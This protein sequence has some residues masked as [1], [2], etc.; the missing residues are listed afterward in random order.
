[1][2]YA[3]ILGVLAVV[4]LIFIMLK[5]RNKEEASVKNN[6]SSTRRVSNDNDGEEL[7]DSDV[8]I[9]QINASVSDEGQ[10]WEWDTNNADLSTTSVSAQEVDPLTEYQVY[11]QF[12]YEDKAA[13]SLAKYLNA[14]K[15]DV[16][17]RLVNELVGLCLNIRDVDLLS[18]SLS[19]YASVLSQTALTEYVKAGLSIDSNH[20]GLR[21]LAESKLNWS[22]QEVARQ[23]GEQTGLDISDSDNGSY[24]IDS[25]VG[26]AANHDG[27]EV[28]RLVKRSPLIIGKAEVGDMTEEE[29][30]AV[31]GFVKPEKSAKLIKDQVDYETALQQYNKAI[32]K[33]EKPAGLIIDALKLDYQNSDVNEFAA[34]LWKLYYSLGSNG[35]QVKE[36]MLGWGYSLGQHEVFDN[37]ER[38]PTEQQIREIGLRYG[39]LQP[40]TRQTKFKYREL[41]RKNDFI[42][43]EGTSPA[44]LAL[45]EV[46]SLLM[47][48]QLDQAISTLEQAVLQHPQESQ[49]YIMLFDLYERSEDW[50]G[51]GQFLRSLREREANLPEEVV[52]AIS[53]LQQRIQRNSYK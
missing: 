50:I 34:H 35:R 22:M 16:P 29:M 8:W 31:I 36:R 14:L 17:E 26:G 49:L 9:G 45:K 32:Q 18:S 7:A 53:Q 28:K 4:V 30:S 1:M 15:P 46:E 33:A 48:G 42:L 38:T 20:L 11:K 21:V 37:L 13:A 24:D 27:R 25:A 47:Y 12:G 51:L 5:Q 40:G 41:V 19:E 23:I 3:L 10:G 39:Y 6:Q 43:N 2:D 52:L 44:E